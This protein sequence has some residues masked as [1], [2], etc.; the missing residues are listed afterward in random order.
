MDNKITFGA[1]YD[2]SDKA[3]LFSKSQKIKI[4]KLAH[5][6]GENDVICIGTRKY[7]SIDMQTGKEFSQKEA[8]VDYIVGELKNSIKLDEN[9]LSSLV[10]T[11]LPE[12]IKDVH[13]KA[14]VFNYVTNILHQLQPYKSRNKYFRT[15][16]EKV[17]DFKNMHNTK[18]ELRQWSR[19]KNTSNK[20]SFSS[21]IRDKAYKVKDLFT[22]SI[23]YI[24]NSIG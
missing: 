17:S 8:R 5:S 12:K 1:R 16:V 21:K 24:A 9:H 7:K 22:D 10:D 2:L 15:F 6:L 13:F 11:N 3:R 19:L 4:K 18:L 23:E 14:Q 20:D